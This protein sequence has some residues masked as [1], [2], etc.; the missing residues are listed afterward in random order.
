MSGGCHLPAL[1]S[2]RDGGRRLFSTSSNG[3][4][5]PSDMGHT[6]A[7]SLRLAWAHCV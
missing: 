7:A 3:G 1:G 4:P 6:A 5:M 2:G